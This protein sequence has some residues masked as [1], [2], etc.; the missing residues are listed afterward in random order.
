[1]AA[2]AIRFRELANNLPGLLTIHNSFCALVTRKP[3][4][5]DRLICCDRHK[6]AA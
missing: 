2:E 4:G 1:V 3:E 6:Q 5:K